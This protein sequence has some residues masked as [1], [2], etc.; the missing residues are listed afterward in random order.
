[1]PPVSKNKLIIYATSD[2]QSQAELRAT[3]TLQ[4]GGSIDEPLTLEQQETALA[5]DAHE[6]H[7]ELRLGSRLGRGLWG[8]GLGDGAGPASLIVS[9]DP[10]ERV[11]VSWPAILF[12]TGAPATNPRRSVFSPTGDLRLPAASLSG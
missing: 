6:V 1:M 3:I 2:L 9:D 8:G 5:E 12:L 7:G 4:G 10:T 11:R